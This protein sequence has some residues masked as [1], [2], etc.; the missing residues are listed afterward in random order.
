MLVVVANSVFLFPPVFVC[1]RNQKDVL[2]VNQTNYVRAMLKIPFTTG[3][4][5]PE[6]IWFH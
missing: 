2:E 5:A 1:D 4:P 6:E 3:P